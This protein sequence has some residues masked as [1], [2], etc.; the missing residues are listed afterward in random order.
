MAW[1]VLATPATIFSNA[2]PAWRE[3]SL[4][5]R[6][7]LDR[8]VDQFG[9]FLGGLRGALGQLAHFVGHDRETQAML[10]GARRFDGC[11]EGQHIGLAGDLAD[12]LDDLADVFGRAVDQLHRLDRARRPPWRR[13]RA[14]PG[15]CPWP[16]GRRCG[17]LVGDR[18][19]RGRSVRR[20]THSSLRPW[21]PAAAAPAATPL[22]RSAISCEL[23]RSRWPLS[24]TLPITLR[25]SLDHL[26]DAVG[27]L[28]DRIV[29]VDARLHPSGRP[30][31]RS[32][33]ALSRRLTLR[34]SSAARSFTLS[35]SS[36]CAVT[37]M[38]NFTTLSARPLTSR[39]G[40]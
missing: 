29:A 5:T 30:R 39:I 23:P 31:R 26:V 16:D 9:D 19:D 35:S 32:R 28:I 3:I 24:T 11:V 22:E 33:T 38:A 1:V 7:A 6:H 10:T 13:A 25:R 21:R 8:L 27:E 37:S 34:W 12:H 14:S 2:S 36:T 15:A 4:P 17:W 20:S 18:V 40:L